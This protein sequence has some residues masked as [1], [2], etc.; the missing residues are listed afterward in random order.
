VI[1]SDRP[2]SPLASAAQ[3]LIG[4]GGGAADLVDRFA[5][6][7]AAIDRSTADALL[8]ELAALGLVRVARGHG[9]DRFVVL[10]TLG[11]RTSE[12][13]RGDEAALSDLLHD[14]ERMRT[15]LLSTIAHEL[16]TPLTAVRTNV[17]LLRDPASR[18]TTEQ[19][20]ALLASIERNAERMQRLVDDS[21]DL[22]RFRAGNVHLQLRRFDA[23]ELARSVIAARSPGAADRLRLEI[24]G[25]RPVWVFGDRRRLDHALDNLVA[26]ALTYS[27]ESEPVTIAVRAIDDEVRWTV[28]DRGIGIP[29][30]DRAR[31]FERFFVGRRDRSGA[32][33]GVGLGLPIV[34]AI[35]G[36]HDGRVEVDSAPGEGSRFTIAVPAAGP[37]EGTEP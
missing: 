24:D 6:A 20:D 37:R 4:D 25:D 9:P 18:P 10:T 1:E 2:R 19:Q 28:T 31:L 32:R 30:E 29:D 3:T 21:L 23:T 35:V 36:A 13:G 16:R 5:A 34:L 22:T 26:N 33:D 12:L 27:P 14:L 17:G 8:D 15:D 11:Q 7:G